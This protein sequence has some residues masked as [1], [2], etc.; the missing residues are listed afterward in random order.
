VTINP[1]LR[2]D[3]RFYNDGLIFTENDE[4]LIDIC[5]E[6]SKGAVP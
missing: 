1:I 2:V 4:Y 5:I 3:L 6:N